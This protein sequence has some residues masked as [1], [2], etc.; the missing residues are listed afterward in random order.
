MAA[1]PALTLFGLTEF[2]RICQHW[3]VNHSEY[4]EMLRRHALRLVEKNGRVTIDD[5]RDEMEALHIPMPSDIGAD[6]RIFGHVLRGCKELRIVGFEPTRRI[7]HAK[8]VGTTRAQISIY[9]NKAD[10]Q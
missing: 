8:R 4:I 1:L 6:D 10:P 5:V 7:E 2:E 3:Q 9:I